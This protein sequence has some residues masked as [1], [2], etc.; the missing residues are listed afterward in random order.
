MIGIRIRRL[1]SD[2]D[3]YLV[4]V[5]QDIID[6]K[7]GE[8]TMAIV[9]EYQEVPAQ[10]NQGGRVTDMVGDAAER[11]IVLSRPYN[12]GQDRRAS[13]REFLTKP[14]YEDRFGSIDRADPNVPRYHGVAVRQVES[15]PSADVPP[16]WGSA[17]FKNDHGKLIFVQLKDETDPFRYGRARGVWWRCMP[18]GSGVVQRVV[19]PSIL[20][21]LEEWYGK[22][23][24]RLAAEAKPS[25]TYT[26]DPFDPCPDVANSLLRQA[27]Q[28]ELSAN[29]SE[30]E[31][32][33]C[34]QEAHAAFVL[35]DKYRTHAASLR[36][37]AEK[38]G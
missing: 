22:R 23:G 24:Q 4:W 26:Y 19:S 7:T 14:E 17:E 34:M 12:A 38:I 9:D 13:R 6:W 1:P 5:G 3:R 35:A 28:A 25:D 8:R 21:E 10:P 32:N 16:V 31:G 37:A 33:R 30:A 15:L 27:S 2:P 20:E 11:P 36:A 29:A 18:F